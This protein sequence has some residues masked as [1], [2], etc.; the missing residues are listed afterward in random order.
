MAT[1][2][3]QG[4]HFLL[5]K[6]LSMFSMIGI[7]ALSGIVIND[8]LV[9]IDFINRAFRKGEPISAALENSGRRRFR[10]I[11]LTSLTTVAGL[12]PLLF[13][14]SI[15]AHIIIPMAI[16]I[17]LGL[18]AAT[19]LTLLFVPLLYHILIDMKTFLRW[20]WTGIWEVSP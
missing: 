19:L 15:Q 18:I 2:R 5:G 14:K 20:S 17:S 3:Y 10:A 12:L 11:L 13:E 9:M 16:S 7:V 1:L 4:G 6:D 8:A